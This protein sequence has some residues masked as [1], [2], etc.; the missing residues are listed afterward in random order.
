MLLLLLLLLW[1][2]KG[3]EGDMEAKESYTQEVKSAGKAAGVRFESEAAESGCKMKRLN[4]VQSR[5]WVRIRKL[6][7]R[8]RT[9]QVN[10]RTF[11]Q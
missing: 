9:R 7:I 2:L 5:K 3:I 6:Q 4:L 11:R 8:A 1:G 10:N